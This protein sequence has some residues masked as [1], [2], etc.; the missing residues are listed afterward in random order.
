MA[1]PRKDR[2]TGPARALR[3]LLVVL[4][5]SAPLLG[6]SAT[7]DTFLLR[8]Q[9]LTERVEL[10][11]YYAKAALLAVDTPVADVYTDE[12][13]KLLIAAESEGF[14]A[15]SFTDDV[16]EALAALE[17][18]RV[19]KQTR[20]LIANS[21][22]SVLDYA[23]L[24]MMELDAIRT[25][26]SEGGVAS[27]EAVRRILAY[28][29][30]ARGGIPFGLPGLVDVRALLP[31]AERTAK[32]G[33]SLQEHIDDLSPGGVLHLESGTYSLAEGLVIDKSMTLQAAARATEPIQLVMQE[34]GTSAVI[35]IT[36]ATPHPIRVEL[37]DLTISAGPVGISIG[38]VSGVVSRGPVDVTLEAITVLDCSRSGV[39]VGSGAVRLVDCRLAGNGEYG[40]IIP[41]TGTADLSS[42]AIVANGTAELLAMDYRATGGVHVTGEGEIALHSCTV[43]E[44]IGPGL[45]AAGAATLALVSTSIRGNDGDGVLVWDRVSLHVQDCS[46][47]GNQG[48]GILLLAEECAASPGAAGVHRFEGEVAGSGNVIPND[49]SEDGNRRGAV[50][51]STY[52]FLIADE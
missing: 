18:V 26:R 30:A 2:P 9:A 42:C 12:M 20:A 11:M 48:F 47:K 5:I 32:P 10:A 29:S 50:C 36:A 41:W 14:E 31:N 39:R 25:E 22:E 4:S 16:V 1:R 7:D 17:G 27:T 52:G 33:D 15:V 45:W 51:P 21:L 46:I 34:D 40:L 19:D 49:T 28:L 6:A 44:N 8:I 38:E 37:R 43:A 35:S 3:T 13:T 24:V 23:R